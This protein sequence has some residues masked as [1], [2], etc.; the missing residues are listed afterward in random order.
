MP[1]LNIDGLKIEYDI[2]DCTDKIVVLKTPMLLDEYRRNVI[3]ITIE[4][5]KQT[6]NAKDIVVIPNYLSFKVKSIDKTINIL[7]RIIMKL[8]ADKQKL[9]N[10]RSKENNE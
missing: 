1:N 9:E 6:C 3:D 4:H 7:N 2:F 10:M 5:I 8:S